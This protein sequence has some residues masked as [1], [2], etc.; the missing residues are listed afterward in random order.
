MKISLA[1]VYKITQ[2]LIHIHIEDSHHA[3]DGS[4]PSFKITLGSFLVDS[5][6]FDEDENEPPSSTVTGS[7]G[8]PFLTGDFSVFAGEPPTVVDA[9]PPAF[10]RSLRDIAMGGVT[11]DTFTIPLSSDANNPAA[12]STQGSTGPDAPRRFLVAF[13]S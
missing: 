3:V 6:P 4:G 1:L 8:L 13:S 9:L 11:P 12:F 5:T 7:D 2:V 10:F